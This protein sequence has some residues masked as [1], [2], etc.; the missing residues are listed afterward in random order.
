MLCVVVQAMFDETT[1]GY[2]YARTAVK[3]ATAKTTTDAK[4]AA[5][6]VQK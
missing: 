4:H 3:N 5:S 2:I 6:A 1:R